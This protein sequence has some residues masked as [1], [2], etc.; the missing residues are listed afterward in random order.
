MEDNEIIAALR[1]KCAASGIK[2][3]ELMAVA[4]PDREDYCSMFIASQ[5]ESLYETGGGQTADEA[6]A[7]LRA[8]LKTPAQLAA[9]KRE[10]AAKLLAEAATLSPEDKP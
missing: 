10:A 6:I 7:K 9:E 2:G 5:S 8:K 4:G 1:A 3:I